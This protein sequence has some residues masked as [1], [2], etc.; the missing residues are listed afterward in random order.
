MASKKLEQHIIESFRNKNPEHQN[1]FLLHLYSTIKENADL[2]DIW[3]L[4]GEEKVM[5]RLITAIEKETIKRIGRSRKLR[6]SKLNDI[7]KKAHSYPMSLLHIIALQKQVW[8]SSA[9]FVIQT[10]YLPNLYREACIR[11][12]KEYIDSL[13]NIREPQEKA[14]RI[15]EMKT[16][17]DKLQSSKAYFPQLEELL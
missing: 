16:F 10:G 12:G 13:Q 14:E 11:W 4:E 1:K 2:F 9:L 6:I 5:A 15:A 17:I 3:L 7:I 8:E